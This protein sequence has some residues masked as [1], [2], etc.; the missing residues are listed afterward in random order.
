MGKLI[1]VTRSEIDAMFD[2]GLGRQHMTKILGRQVDESIR[3]FGGLVIDPREFVAH[4]FVTRGEAQIVNKRLQLVKLTTM[5]M[6]RRVAKQCSTSRPNWNFYE[7]DG[8]ESIPRDPRMQSIPLPLEG[9]RRR[10][11]HEVDAGEAKIA[12]GETSITPVHPDQEVP[13]TPDEAAALHA[14]L[15]AQQAEVDAAAQALAEA[16]AA[17]RQ[18]VDAMAAL[19]AAEQAAG[20]HVEGSQ[21]ATQTGKMV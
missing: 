15:R 14:Q 7:V 6:A 3:P 16:E 21:D 20:Q 12:R 4:V 18:P 1:V 8:P 2:P 19:A 11:L 17:Q 9:P 13:Q 5:E 10:S